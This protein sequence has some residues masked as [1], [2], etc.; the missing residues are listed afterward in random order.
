MD[1]K[2]T[3][4]HT[5]QIVRYDQSSLPEL[6]EQVAEKPVPI[7]VKW[8]LPAW[9]LRHPG[10]RIEVEDDDVAFEEGT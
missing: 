2:Q 8:N 10:K 9:M 4:Q 1:L 5:S 6:N 7:E 3:S